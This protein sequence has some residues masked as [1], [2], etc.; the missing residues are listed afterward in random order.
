[1]ITQVSFSSATVQFVDLVDAGTAF[2][3]LSGTSSL[4]PAVSQERGFGR[5]PEAVAEAV[6]KA[7]R[8]SA[9]C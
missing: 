1:M 3:S 4:V 2:G 9:T 5:V 8:A 6:P 7:V